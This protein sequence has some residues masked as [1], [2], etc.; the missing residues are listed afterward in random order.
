[1]KKIILILLAHI[2]LYT[3]SAQIYLSRTATVTFFSKTPMED[4]KA[5]NNQVYAA[6]D[7]GNKSVAFSL[8]LKSFNFRKELMEEHF[9]EDYVESEKFPKATFSGSY[10]GNVDLSKPGHYSVTVKGKLSLHNVTRE[11]EIPADITVSN[12][13]LTGTS[14]FSVNPGDFNIQI[15]ALV[16]D[17]IA[18]EITVSVLADCILKNSR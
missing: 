16:R 8:L 2:C 10:E 17:K 5:V 1:M 12:N 7:A 13:N 11:I 6:I 4:I 14:S 18:K 15:P 3:A 9:N